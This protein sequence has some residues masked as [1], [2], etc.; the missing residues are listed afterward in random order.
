MK[1]RASEIV[2]D[3]R[4]VVTARPV[5]SQPWPGLVMVHEAWGIDDVLRRLADRL[6]SAGYLVYAPDLWVGV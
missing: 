2:L 3:G 5:A 1:T 6:A 4:T